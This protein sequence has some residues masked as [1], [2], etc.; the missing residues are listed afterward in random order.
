MYDFLDPVLV[1][2][3]DHVSLFGW[4]V[5]VLVKDPLA[6]FTYVFFTERA[7]SAEFRIIH[8]WEICG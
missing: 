7:K 3:D 6:S 8:A 1:I 4:C 2:I 5:V